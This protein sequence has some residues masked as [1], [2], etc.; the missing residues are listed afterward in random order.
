MDQRRN[1]SDKFKDANLAEVLRELD[2][3]IQKE[4]ERSTILLNYFQ[5]FR[6]RKWAIILCLIAVVVPVTI[7]TFCTT[8][9]FRAEAT[10]IYE[11]PQDT[12]FAL[13]MGQ[14][15]YNKSS[16]IN[17]IEQIKSRRLAD[18]VAALL[19]KEV[20]ST[21]KFPDPLPKKFSQEKFIGRI[22]QKN[23]S[24]E[25]VRGGDILKISMEANDPTAAMVITNTYVNK[26]IDWNLQKKREEI[27][28]VRNFVERQ[29][30][31]FQDRLNAAEDAL[32]DFKEQHNMV[33]LSDASQEVLKNLTDAEVSYNQAKTE[34]EALEQ[35]KRYIE[36][37]KRE[38]APSLIVSNSKST[39]QLKQDLLN[40]ETQYSNLQLQASPEDQTKLASLREK[41][42]QTKQ[43]LINEL[44]RNAMREN[45]VDPLSQLRSLLQESITIEVDLE[46]YKA[47]EQG[48]KRIMDDYNRQLQTLPKQELELARYIRAKEVNDKIYSLLLEKREE[49]RIT[50]A[51]K[52]GDV[53]VIDPA[54]E[55]LWPV[56]PMKKKTVAIG[57][58]LGMMLGIGMALFLEF[59]D[60]TIKT[61]DDVEKHLN[62]PI[63]ASI[64]NLNTNGFLSIHKRNKHVKETYVKKILP[65]FADVPHLFE[66]YRTLH[67]NFSFVNP[68]NKLKVILVTSSRAGEGKTLTA[69][70]MA[71]MFARAGAK[72]IL[73]DCDLRRPMVH[74]ILNLHQEPGLSNLLIKQV[75]LSQVIQSSGSD[76]LSILTCGVLP[77]NPSEMLNSVRMEQ[78]LEQLRSEYDMVFLDTPPV[79][80]VTDAVILGSKTD[81]VCLVVESGK[82]A[83]EIVTRAKKIFERGGIRI[84]GIIL[85]NV[86]LKNTYGNYKDYYYYSSGKK[87]KKFSLF[88]T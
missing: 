12:M 51:G 62:L 80:A 87:K 47:R 8:P 71:Q 30:S 55:P 29:L 49:A 72:T 86:N 66:A 39:E 19:P 60:N 58:V 25:A 67:L 53:R 35:R 37:K 31:I 7:W 24:I 88:K 34:R 23:L 81:G 64:P 79:I 20:I 18:E 82:T 42:N 1:P 83:R 13:D 85:N 54:E 45:L 50:E 28:N 46:T 6:R 10:I 61:E 68:D 75:E 15:F 57:F 4:P 43:D 36:Q 65:Q 33:S 59:M 56:K 9:I 76:G 69:I 48:L 70:N 52:I 40:L 38:V 78:L 17:M 77:P 44:M 73:I 26:I 22:L 63:L 14:P 11:E 32:L 84:I 16:V 27:S 5:M 74:K 2:L 41:I 3:L 21:F